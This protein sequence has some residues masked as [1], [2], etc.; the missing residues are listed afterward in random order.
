MHLAPAAGRSDDLAAA[1]DSLHTPARRWKLQMPGLVNAGRCVAVLEYVQAPPAQAVGAAERDLAHIGDVVDRGDSFALS[2]DRLIFA[3]GAV[4]GPIRYWYCMRRREDFSH[5]DFLVRYSDVHSQFGLQTTGIEGY[6]QWHADLE[7]SAAAGERLGL[8]TCPYDS[9]SV[10]EIADL[11]TFFTAAMSTDV[12]ERAMADE[13]MFVDR[14][15][16]HDH[17]LSLVSLPD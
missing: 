7:A 11:D 1:V 8:G 13:E 17:I 14:A 12:G 15:N 5:D 9:I 10:L 4:V 6:T 3:G 16:S 2:G